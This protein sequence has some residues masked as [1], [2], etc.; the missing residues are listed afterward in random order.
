MLVGDQKQNFIFERK[1]PILSVAGACPVSATGRI[2]AG[3][4]PEIKFQIMLR[5]V[6]RKAYGKRN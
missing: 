3:L 1:M 5:R 6:L 4:L 2:E